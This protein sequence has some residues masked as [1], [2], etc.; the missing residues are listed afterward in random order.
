MDK[1]MFTSEANAAYLLRFRS[2]FFRQDMESSEL[3]ISLEEEGKEPAGEKK[4]LCRSCLLVITERDEAI[5]FQGSHE[6]TFANPH[7]V[8]YRIGCFRSAVGCGYAGH[9]SDE[10]TWFPGFKWRIALCA[11]C[12]THLGWLFTKDTEGGFH[13]LIVDRLIDS[14]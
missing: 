14:Q 12:L 1:E 2:P 11:L 8:V 10:F 3:S 5:E 4:L 7:G 6:H 13:G 9:P